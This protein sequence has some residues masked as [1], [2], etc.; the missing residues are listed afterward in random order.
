MA[1]ASMGSYL[2]SVPVEWRGYLVRV[3]PADPLV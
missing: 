2:A 1:V 3:L